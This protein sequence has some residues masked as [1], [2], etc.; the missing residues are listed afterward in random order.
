MVNETKTTERGKCSINNS[1]RVVVVD[2]CKKAKTADPERDSC[3]SYY[4]GKL[5]EL[6]LKAL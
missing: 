2:Y 1:R 5:E 3:C 6:P 4:S